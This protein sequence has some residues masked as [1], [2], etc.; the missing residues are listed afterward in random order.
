MLI[1][2]MNQSRGQKPHWPGIYCL[3]SCPVG[4]V[5]FS[6]GWKISMQLQFF[7]VDHSY[8]ER[9]GEVLGQWLF[10]KSNNH[11]YQKF[12]F[13][14]CYLIYI[15]LPDLTNTQL[16][17]LFC[18][19]CR[20]NIDSDYEAKSEKDCRSNYFLQTSFLKQL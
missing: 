16:F 3:T 12:P 20:V 17:V 1:P 10:G 15:F 18:Q 19:Y 11:L 14:C 13:T 7:F 4:N 2:K 9:V 6:V 5:I 8:W